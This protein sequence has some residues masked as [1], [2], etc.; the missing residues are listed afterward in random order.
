MR[1]KNDQTGGR[2]GCRSQQYG[3]S[4][5]ILCFS[6][7]FVKFRTGQINREFNSGINGLGD[8]D[9]AHRKNEQTPFQAFDLTD[10]TGGCDSHGCDKMNPRMS[11]RP[12]QR[13]EAGKCKSKCSD[14]AMRRPM[15][16][17]FS[18]RMT[19]GRQVTDVVYRSRTRSI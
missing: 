4:G 8:P 3:T 14:A 19:E 7:R 1:P 9:Q 16:L 13:R 5:D 18:V 17:M 10:R 6:G 12:K 2:G 15:K 11:L